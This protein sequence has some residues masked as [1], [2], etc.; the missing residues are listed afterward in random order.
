MAAVSAT[1]LP[2]RRVP[3]MSVFDT[4]APKG[5]DDLLVNIH[6]VPGSGKTWAALSA[7]NYW[8]K[9][10]AKNTKPVVL[11]DTIHIGW[12]RGGLVGV[13]PHKIR[14]A[15][16]V[17]MPAVLAAC[18]GDIMKSCERVI[19]D[20]SE[21]VNKHPE[22]RLIVHDTCTRMDR[23]FVAFWMDPKNMPTNRQDVTDTRAAYG[24]IRDTHH[25]YQSSML[26]TRAGITSV[27][28]FHQKVLEEAA[29][30]K[31]DARR[32]AIARQAITKLGDQLVNVVP[33]ITGQS[34][35]VYTADAS[36]ELVAVTTAVPNTP[37]QFAYWLYPVVHRG[38][39]AKNRFRSV[40][41]DKQPADLGA[42][43]SRVR[44]SAT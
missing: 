8:P 21:L 30:G 20:T 24:K 31:E 25:L 14:P 9:D 11:K 29:G 15:Y 3:A 10:P 5:L 16:C 43:I 42:L 22:I 18:K 19:N 26:Q 4:A 13:L 41:A 2:P 28:L 33:D 38:Q 1:D 34:L 27:F 23:Y 17:D 7:S 36:L 6:G 32:A 37:G 44:K 35:N 40:I 12:D 39:R